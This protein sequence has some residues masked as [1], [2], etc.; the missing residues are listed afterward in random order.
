MAAD[1]VS[2]N[3]PHE[4]RVLRDCVDTL[5][6]MATYRLPS[7]L[8]HRLLW[9][10]ENKEQLDA[11]QREELAAFVELA[12]NRSLDKVQAKAV[13]DQLARIYPELAGDGA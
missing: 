4:E 11:R 6:R 9:L 1:T 13:L 7:A 10:S 8:D 12:D 3:P 2:L 5:R